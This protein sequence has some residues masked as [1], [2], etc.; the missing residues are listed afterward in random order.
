M[1]YNEDGSFREPPSGF[2]SLPIVRRFLRSAA[3][4]AGLHIY[5][6]PRPQVRAKVVVLLD[7]GDATIVVSGSIGPMTFPYWV[8]IGSVLPKKAAVSALSF[9]TNISLPEDMFNLVDVRSTEQGEIEHDF[10]VLVPADQKSE[11]LRQ[12]EYGNTKVERICGGM[13]EGWRAELAGTAKLLENSRFS[14]SGLLQS[15]ISKC[16]EDRVMVSA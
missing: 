2:F 11:V 7:D 14:Q 3:R 8:C 9:F 6:Y 10:Y 16:M 5:D 15:A 13:N 12:L 4:R 1:Y